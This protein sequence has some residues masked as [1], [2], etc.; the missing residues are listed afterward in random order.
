MTDIGAVDL[1]RSIEELYR[2]ACLKSL[3]TLIYIARLYWANAG[4]I[5]SNIEELQKMRRKTIGHGHLHNIISKCRD[6]GHF[7]QVCL[8]FRMRYDIY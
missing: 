1:P 4:T 2:V 8:G 3:E 7:D 6:T 5:S